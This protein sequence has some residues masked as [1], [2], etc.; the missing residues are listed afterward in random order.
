MRPKTIIIADN[1]TQAGLIA[2]MHQLKPWQWRYGYNAQAIMGLSPEAA[3]LI[4]SG[5]RE[6]PV[7]AGRDV[8][9]FPYYKYPLTD[10]IRIHRIQGG[11]VAWV[12][13]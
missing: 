5:W 2:K 12:A 10:L 3:V 4:A 8:N 6:T 1:Q 13:I 7:L 9:G 11:E